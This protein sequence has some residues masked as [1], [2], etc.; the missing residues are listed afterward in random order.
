MAIRNI[1]PGLILTLLITLLAIL[2]EKLPFPPFTLGSG[3]H[4]IESMAIGLLL[5]IIVANTCNLAKV[6][7][8]GID[9]AM[10]SLLSLGI[11]LLGFKL[12][13]PMLLN[14]PITVILIVV[15]TS[16][17]AL[18]SA[19]F[20]GKLLTNDS[21]TSFLIGIGNAICGGSAIIAAAQS[22]PNITKAQIIT[23]ITVVNLLG[24]VLIFM[25]TPLAHWL[26]LSHLGMGV[27]AGAIG[28]A[29]PQATAAGFMFSH[30]AGVYAT[31][32][33]L[34]RVLQLGPYLIYIRCQFH[35]SIQP[36]P[37]FFTTLFAYIPPFI[38]LFIVAMILNSYVPSPTFMLQTIH[39]N[40]FRTLAHSSTL[41]LTMALTA[42]G[43][44]TELKLILDE[45]RVNLLIGLF[46]TAC[47]IGSVI[48]MLL[49]ANH[50]TPIF[51]FA[52]A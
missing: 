51:F 52:R 22:I 33:K 2:L 17:L 8:P 35:Q 21:S 11:I 13:M 45:G 23:A 44:S 39:F 24:L 28:Q 19:M 26:N 48:M 40:L 49:I 27:L 15:L 46:S 34:V 31:L 16:L 41:F 37:S 38:I 4:P 5:G 1:V 7:K 43:L 25:L 9:F 29:V 42:M 50:W 3:F 47:A 18:C 20:I 30:A 36:N 12:N 32:I 6:L 14:L 10:S